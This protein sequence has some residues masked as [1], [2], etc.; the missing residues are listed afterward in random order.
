MEAALR[1]FDEPFADPSAIPVGLI[2]RAAREEGL[3]CM[4]SGDGGDEFFGGY[5]RYVR[6]L[7][8]WQAGAPPERVLRE[9]LSSMRWISESELQQ[10]MGD[11][12][13]G[14]SPWETY[15]LSAAPSRGAHLLDWLQ[16]LDLEAYLPWNNLQKVDRAS[17]AWGLEVRVP[18]VDLGVARV[19]R[20]FPAGLRVH[21]RIRK[22][23]LKEAFSD[24]LPERLLHRRKRGFT[25]PVHRWLPK[26][27]AARILRESGL[28]DWLPGVGDAQEQAGKRAGYRRWLLV[29]LA[30]W[31]QEA[32][33]RGL[34]IQWG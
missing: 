11:R 4:V 1:R 18:L 32:E 6:G 8:R 25:V 27:R 33:Q 7:R 24:V 23:V 28:K 31:K 17:M 2:C 16:W 21:G 30:W 12:Y 34:A 29:A 19:T 15:L 9:I 10:L 20:H 13:P 26:E 22:W 3:K 5:G 14:A